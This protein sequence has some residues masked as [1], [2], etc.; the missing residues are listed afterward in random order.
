MVLPNNKGGGIARN[1]G[2]EKAS[3][4]YYIFG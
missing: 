1:Y 2:I 4:S 3:G